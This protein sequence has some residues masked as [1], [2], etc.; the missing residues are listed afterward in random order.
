M[1]YYTL[2]KFLH[3]IGLVV[4][5]GGLLAVFVSELRAYGTND[6][7]IFSE[8]ARY[9]AIFYDALVAP[10]AVILAIS[11]VLLVF[12][13]RLGF[14]D[15]PWLVGMWALFAFEFVEGNTVTRVQFRRALRVSRR[16]LAEGHLTPEVRR[17]ARATMG[18]FTHF[19]DIPLFGV[20]VYCGA[21]RP[22][23]W[24]DILVALILAVL[25]SM[26]LAIIVPR[27]AVAPSRP[28]R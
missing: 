23:D 25:V 5:G 28:D 14:F 9:A 10:G 27:I 24:L 2:L 8:A 1:D 4:L 18:T 15:D 3:I 20:I 16:A 21:A 17:E 6:I 22:S 19:L 7:G 26:S 13:L 11:G 12:E